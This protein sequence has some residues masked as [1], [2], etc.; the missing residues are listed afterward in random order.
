MVDG[1][2]RQYAAHAVPPVTGP[3][4]QAGHGPHSVVALVLVA[5]LPRHLIDPQQS[6]VAGA[7][8]DRAPADRYLAGIPEQSTGA[9]LRGAHVGLLAQPGRA[10]LHRLPTE[11]FARPE[12]VPLT[13]ASVT[14]PAIAK[15]CLQVLP[16]RF[17][18][19]HDRDRHL[20][21]HAARVNVNPDN[22]GPQSKDPPKSRHARRVRG[23]RWPHTFVATPAS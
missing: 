2:G 16:G 6:L 13:L 9:S 11:C 17:V 10:F 1:G 7:G 23:A 19:R 12:L 8:F 4:K 5:T 15:D 20:V 18:G 21:R 3:D 14:R 22:R